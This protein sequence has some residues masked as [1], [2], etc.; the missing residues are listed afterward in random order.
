MIT[1][2]ALSKV[3]FDKGLELHQNLTIGKRKIYCVTEKGSK[4]AL[5]AGR[6]GVISDYV[7]TYHFNEGQPRS[8][9]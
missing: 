6:L 7:K 8:T 5:N 1:E 4:K 9:Y 2:K 3:C